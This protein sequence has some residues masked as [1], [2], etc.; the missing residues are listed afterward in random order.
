MCLVPPGGTLL[1]CGPTSFLPSGP[2][3][4]SAVPA[5]GPQLMALALHVEVENGLSGPRGCP[6]PW[7]RVEGM[8]E[9][10]VAAYDG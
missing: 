10:K 9:S 8:Q 2:G 6:H 1:N 4:F 3:L 5:P 7:P